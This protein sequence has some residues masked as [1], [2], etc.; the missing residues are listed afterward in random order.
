MKEES[1]AQTEIIEEVYGRLAATMG[2]HSP[3]LHA[4]AAQALDQFTRWVGRAVVS[5]PSR[6][7]GVVGDVRTNDLTLPFISYRFMLCYIANKQHKRGV[8]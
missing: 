4:G 7:R 5:W 1:I 6:P 8:A 3:R 2:N